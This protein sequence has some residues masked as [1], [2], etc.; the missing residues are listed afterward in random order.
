MKKKYT[1]EE[2]PELRVLM[3]SLQHGDDTESKVIF[4]FKNA[5]SVS[6]ELSVTIT[7]LRNSKVV[8]VPWCFKGYILRGKK[9]RRI[10][11][12]GLLDYVDDLT[13]NISQSREK[14]VLPRKRR[15]YICIG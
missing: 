15:S 8:Q 12:N 13:R 11:V 10:A 14:V 1:L 5:R 4:K 9:L 6:R 3:L 2:I 7:E